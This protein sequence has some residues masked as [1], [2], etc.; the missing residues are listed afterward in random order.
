MA[1]RASERGRG[2]VGGGE[3]EE[4]A[5]G[6][7]EGERPGAWEREEVQIEEGAPRRRGAQGGEE[8]SGKGGAHVLAAGL[9]KDEN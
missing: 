1:F 9:K 3:K 7:S 4:G 5:E 6:R 8:S 2:S